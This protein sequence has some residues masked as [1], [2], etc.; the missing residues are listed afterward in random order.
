MHA[1]DLGGHRL[2]EP[3]DPPQ[4]SD[5]LGKEAQELVETADRVPEDSAER[6]AAGSPIRATVL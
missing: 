2:G 6:A 4:L 3:A 1:A 5:D